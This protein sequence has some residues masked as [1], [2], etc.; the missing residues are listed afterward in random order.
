MSSSYEVEAILLSKGEGKNKQYYVKW[1]HYS[2]RDSTWEPIQHLEESPE[3]ITEFENSIEPKIIMHL[4][5]QK[6]LNLK[7]VR[8]I[9]SRG[10]G[11]KKEYLVEWDFHPTPTWEPERTIPKAEIQKY[12]KSAKAPPKKKQK[13]DEASTEESTNPS[14]TKM[15]NGDT[16]KSIPNTSKSTPEPKPS[17]ALT[18]DDDQ[19]N[20]FS[21][22]KTPCKVTNIIRRKQELVVEVAF[23]DEQEKQIF[24][25]DV[26]RKMYPQEVISFLLSRVLFV[27]KK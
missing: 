3:M 11:K 20:K 15:V 7:C 14:V 5:S 10:K 24:S 16:I 12:K 4:S 2:I 17:V 22:T 9:D 6:D 13:I 18:I 19:I 25:M 8:I 23:E 21:N 27:E 1:K 26:V